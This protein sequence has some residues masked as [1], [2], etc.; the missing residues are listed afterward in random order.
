MNQVRD[1]PSSNLPS[2]FIGARGRE[3]SI[4]Q[5]QGARQ[6]L[7]ARGIAQANAVRL[8]SAWRKDGQAAVPSAN[9]AS[10]DPTAL[11]DLLGLIN[12]IAFRQSTQ[13]QSGAGYVEL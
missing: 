5:Q 11:E 3:G 2:T 13:V 8:A 4:R 12:C 7:L 1:H 9:Q 10:R 6:S